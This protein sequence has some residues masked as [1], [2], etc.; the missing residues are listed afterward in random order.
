MGSP[1]GN[2]STTSKS[3]IA[4]TPGDDTPGST[5]RKRKSAGTENLVDFVKD[6][7]FE[8]MARKEAQDKDKRAWRSEMFALDTAREVGIVRKD[9]KVL[10]MDQK[11]YEDEESQ[12]YD[13]RIAHVGIINGRTYKVIFPTLHYYALH[14]FHVLR[15]LG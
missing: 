11:L 1:I 6:F 12:K 3:P 4:C 14:G 13:H 8:Y 9:F 7:N 10:N 15:V 2:A 5:G